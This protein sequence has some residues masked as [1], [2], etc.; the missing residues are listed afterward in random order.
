ML[1]LAGCVSRVALS[2][3]FLQMKSM[4]RSLLLCSK[5]CPHELSH[6]YLSIIR[7][8]DS[9]TSLSSPESCLFSFLLS[10]L[11]GRSKKNAPPPIS[12]RNITNEKSCTQTGFSV[13]SLL[14]AFYLEENACCSED[15]SKEDC[16]RD[17]LQ[18]HMYCSE[19]TMFCFRSGLSKTR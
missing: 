17:K 11:L 6:L 7:R 10:T 4:Q 9:R 3:F 19:R 18:P 14:G 2:E 15:C 12:P 5:D 1:D 13:A 8:A 16:C